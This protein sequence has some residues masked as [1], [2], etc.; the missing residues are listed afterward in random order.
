MVPG[1]DATKCTEPCLVSQEEAAAIT[2]TPKPYNPLVGG[3][4]GSQ[5]HHRSD[6][7]S[8]RK[9]FNFIEIH[10]IPSDLLSA[11]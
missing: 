2:G 8:P 6:I 10:L 5:T 11:L 1:A 7:K 3:G 9:P 4:A